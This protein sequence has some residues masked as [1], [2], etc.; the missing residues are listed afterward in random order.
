MAFTDFKSA[1]EVQK[2]YQVGYVEKDFITFTS[3]SLPEYFVREFEFDRENFDVFGSAVFT[4]NIARV[5]IDRLEEVYGAVFG[6]IE[7]SVNEPP[8]R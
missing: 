8:S 4:K 7:L 3:K 6:L 5:S 1:D 2:A